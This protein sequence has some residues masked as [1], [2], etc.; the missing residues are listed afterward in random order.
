MSEDIKDLL[1]QMKPGSGNKKPSEKRTNN[2]DDIKDLQ[3]Q[4]KA[5]GLNYYAILGIKK[6]ATDIEIKR[7]YNKKLKYYHPDKAEPTKENKIKYNLVRE[8]GKILLDKNRRKAFDLERKVKTEQKGFLSQRD[9]FKEFIKLQEAAVTEESKKMAKLQFEA[10]KRDLDAKRGFK[11][12]DRDPISVEDSNRMLDDLMLQRD[13]EELDVHHNDVFNLGGGGTFNPESF[14]KMFEKAK[15]REN[16][17]TGRDSLVKYEEI[18]AINDDNNFGAAGGDGN[19]D[20]LFGSGNF[21]AFNEDY[22]GFGAGLVGNIEDDGSDLSSIDSDDIEDTYD[23][24]THGRADIEKMMQREMAE[25]KSQNKDFKDLSKMDYKS[26]MDDKF[27]A[28]HGV[29]FMVGFNK[30][31]GGDQV[32]RRDKKNNMDSE[33]IKAYKALLELEKYKNNK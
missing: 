11:E 12:E 21:N 17:K 9:D 15:K 27:G 10:S 22:A 28:S 18:G 24:H 7:A 13:Q 29:G 16:R 4:I 3:K 33:K 20:E 5:D 31:V 30:Y 26:A 25:R 8:A 14:N 23:T 1:N 2:N 6:D 32:R 19:Y